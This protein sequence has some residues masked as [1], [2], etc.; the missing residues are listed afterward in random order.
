MKVVVPMNEVIVVVTAACNAAD[1][2]SATLEVPLKKSTVEVTVADAATLPTLLAPGDEALASDVNCIAVNVVMNCDVA[3]ELAA[4]ELAADEYEL[5]SAADELG[6]AVDELEPA[7]G[8][9]EGGATGSKVRL[10]KSSAITT[11]GKPSSTKNSEAMESNQSHLTG[12][13][14]TRLADD[15]GNVP[16]LFLCCDCSMSF[17]ARCPLLSPR[18]LFGIRVL[19]RSITSRS[20]VKIEGVGILSG[21]ESPH[22]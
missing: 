9:L 14:A 8:E 11:P 10:V 22:A 7:A 6:I 4:D 2:V 17:E 5:E 18:R 15:A 3:E 19:Y 16:R 21:C 13:A 20:V 12:R 1:E